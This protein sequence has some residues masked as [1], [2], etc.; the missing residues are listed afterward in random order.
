[1]RNCQAIIAKEKDLQKANPVFVAE[2]TLPDWLPD[3][4][5]PSELLIFLRALPANQAWACW[6][7]GPLDMSLY[8][9]VRGSCLGR[10]L[11]RDSSERL[12]STYYCEM[13]LA[14][15]SHLVGWLSSVTVQFRSETSSA[16]SPR[17]CKKILKDGDVQVSDREREVHME[18]LWKDPCQR[19]NV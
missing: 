13:V 19:K 10:D 17:I 2:A 4:R 9:G 12:A 11:G 18:G 5:R 6:I 7:T 1:M 15:S 16:P 3:A 14:R 8:W